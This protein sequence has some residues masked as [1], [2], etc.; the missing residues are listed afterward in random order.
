VE[1]GPAWSPMGLVRR[2]SLRERSIARKA[3]TTITIRMTTFERLIQVVHQAKRC[4]NILVMMS[5]F[6][7]SH[8]S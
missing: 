2:A 5:I 1:A 3:T 4:V 8:R 7:A 6:H